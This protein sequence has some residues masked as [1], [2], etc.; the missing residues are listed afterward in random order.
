[1]PAWTIERIREVDRIASESFGIPG[2]VLMENAGR[3]AA[4]WILASMFQASPP[5]PSSPFQ[6]VLILCGCGNNGGDGFVIA[7]HLHAAQ[8]PVAVW[9]F[10][11]FD[12]MAPDARTNHSILAKTRVPCRWISMDSVAPNQDWMESEMGS[13][14]LIV[15][16]MLGT[17]GTG[18]PRRAMATAI[19]VAN[20][21]ANRRSVK[22]IAIDIPTGLN[23]ATGEPHPCTFRADV[24]LT[25]VAPKIGFESPNA[26]EAIG[27]VV[28]LP[29][30]VPPEVIEMVDTKNAAPQRED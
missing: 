18:L 24:T 10:G 20:S 1:M 17:G 25:F 8:V 29:I 13:V 6:R 26:R 3:G 21:V 2:V 9:I 4:D 30:G 28:V 23:A 16:A 15:D 22:R 12:R 5:Q 19:D 11:E 14:D 7:R 27:R